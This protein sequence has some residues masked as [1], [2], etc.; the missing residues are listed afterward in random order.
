MAI[1]KLFSILVLLFA[2]SLEAKA[3]SVHGVF[4][5]VKGKVLIKNKSGKTS[6]AR[7]GMRVYPQD[8][9]KTEKNSRAKIV[10]TDQNVINVSPET[11][12]KL[13]KYEF[14]EKSDKKDVLI[15]VIYGKIRNK[16]SQKYEGKNKFQVKTP[17]A[18][19][20]VRGT[21]FLT[22]YDRRSQKS[23]VITFEGRVE[24]GIPR[25]VDIANSVVVEAGRAS[26][27]V[28]GRG[29]DMPFDLPIAD[30]A[31][32]DS[33][34]DAEAPPMNGP[35]DG[36]DG[37]RQPAEDSEN[38]GEPSN[39]DRGATN[40]PDGDISNAENNPRPIASVDDSN[41][42]MLPPPPD[43]AAFGPLPE[44]PPEQIKPPKNPTDRL[45]P[46][47]I[48]TNRRLIINIQNQ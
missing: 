35:M 3:S 43:D 24:F 33:E 15:D 45:E 30:L 16:V 1:L 32:F 47:L 20:G 23:E 44:P 5:V 36:N 4:K 12:V 14:D 10:M 39:N 40:N 37:N 22:S 46:D 9:I 17:S 28:E 41:G 31:K 48:Q 26:S 34:S 2:F 8:A 6:K 11:E 21:D 19:A 25:G 29:P 18:V 27:M 42:P 13:S 7:I 38:S